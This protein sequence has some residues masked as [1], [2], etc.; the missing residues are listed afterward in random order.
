MKLAKGNFGLVPGSAGKNDNRAKNNGSPE[1]STPATLTK[2]DLIIRISN[3]TGLIQMQ[4]FDLVQ[5]TLD[6]ITEALARGNKVELRNF[7]V[8]EVVVRKARVGRNP[9]N[10]TVEVPIPAH[11]HVKFKAGKL[12]RAEVLKLKPKPS[13]IRNIFSTA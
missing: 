3:E 11:A 10:P 5:K 13:P 6:H 9:K 2:R 1:T 4:V 8:F 7:G 12:M